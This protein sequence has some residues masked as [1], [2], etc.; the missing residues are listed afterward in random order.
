[1]LREGKFGFAEGYS[2]L[3]IS[4]M[5]RIFIG[6]PSVIIEEGK[7][8]A[9]AVVLAGTVG[10]LI[11]FWIIAALMKRHQGLTL[12]ETSE[13]VLGPYL[14]TVVNLFF[15]FFFMDAVSFLDRDY[16]EA[17]ILAALPQTPVSMVIITLKIAVIAS[18]FY[19]LEAMAR[20]ARVSLTFILIGMTLLL[21]SIASY[22]DWTNL[23][24]L[25]SIEPLKILT[26]AVSSVTMISEGLL[27]ALLIHALGGW[28]TFYRAGMLAVAGGGLI[29]FLAVSVVFLTFGV[30]V[31]EELTLPIYSL[32]QIIS[33]GRFFQRLE[34]VFLL[35]WGMVGLMKLAVT[36]YGTTVVLAR[37][38]RLTDYRPLL[39]INAV[40]CLNITFLPP[41]FPTTYM[42]EYVLRSYM[43]II[44]LGLPLLLLVV[45]MVRGAGK[46][47]NDGTETS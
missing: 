16:S 20:V 38:F 6:L 21:I 4:N 19:G 2:L 14:G 27:A 22:L 5:G 42:I 10:S 29:L 37:M 24:P 39:W 1:M 40:L 8:M 31:A 44:T 15:F 34:S 23:Y 17:M 30:Q 11:S 28:Q 36:F 45:S 33:F 12:V 3:L 32:S 47:Q 35:T 25:W 46:Q 13:A 26:T 41:D 7:N 18:C 9:W 43:L